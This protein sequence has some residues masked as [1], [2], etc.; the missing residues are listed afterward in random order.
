M[1]AHLGGAAG[2][3]LQVV[4]PDGVPEVATGDD[5]AALVRSVMELQDGDIVVVT[6][7]AVS[8]A[9]GR[10]FPGDRQE[11]LAAETTR[12]VARA[13]ATTI[14]RNHLGLTMAAAGIDE[15]NIAPG[16]FALLPLDPDAS[17]RKLRSALLCITGCNLAVVITDTSG[18]AWRVGQTDLAIGASGLQV[19]EV[20]DGSTDR[21]GRPLRVT[22]PAVADELAGAAELASGKLTGRPFVRVRGR[23]DLVLPVTEHGPGASTLVRAPADD[24]FGYGAREAVMAALRGIDI[25]GF[26]RPAQFEDLLDALSDAGAE[27]V[28]AEP[29]T[30]EVRGPNRQLLEVVA[31]AHGWVRPDGC[32]E[33]CRLAPLDVVTLVPAYRVTR[34]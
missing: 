5:L 25:A 8:K 29:G 31:F 2:N 11:A 22:F 3:E 16:H 21:F 30:V 27:T 10:L 14:V 23:A 19:I 9:E 32:G 13:G 20:L 28:S 6:S 17:A 4:A 7:K 34:S 18:R 24:L 33:G 12:L 15:S 26:G 1:S